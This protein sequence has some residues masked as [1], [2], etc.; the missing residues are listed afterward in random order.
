M[1]CPFIVIRSN[2]VFK[3]GESKYPF[4]LGENI[5]RFVF[6]KE[7]ANQ[8]IVFLLEKGIFRLLRAQSS[9]YLQV[10]AGCLQFA[11]GEGFRRVGVI[12]TSAGQ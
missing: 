11:E 6:P 12:L 5:W 7:F 2:E 9:F 1:C 8:A 4:V 10:E 3:M